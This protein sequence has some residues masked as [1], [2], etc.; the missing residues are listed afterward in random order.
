[1]KVQFPNAADQ[2][3]TAT[4]EAPSTIAGFAE[5]IHAHVTQLADR[6]ALA[7]APQ[8]TAPKVAN[9]FRAQRS[10]L[11]GDGV[12]SKDEILAEKIHDMIEAA[13][14]AALMMREHPDPERMAKGFEHLNQ[15]YAETAD[16]AVNGPPLSGDERAD[17]AMEA[18]DIYTEML[19]P[20]P[21]QP[22][23]DLFASPTM[24]GH[25]GRG[26]PDWVANA[27]RRLARTQR[28]PDQ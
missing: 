6:L 7:Q 13:A 19:R 22:G 21:M 8:P 17:I 16:R 18:V 9:R 2:T 12:L 25:I 1:M 5:V 3:V 10:D 28:S 14:M 20:E 26:A 11:D 23:Q 15:L 4:V 27:S 24:D